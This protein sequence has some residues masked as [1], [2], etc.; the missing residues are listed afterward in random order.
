[1]I[2]QYPLKSLI[3]HG[4]SQ[5]TFYVSKAFCPGQFMLDLLHLHLNYD[6]INNYT[7]NIVPFWGG[8]LPVQTLAKWVNALDDNILLYTCIHLIITSYINRKAV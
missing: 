2:L 1:M 6:I 3:Y 4:L 8:Q 7:F 5:N